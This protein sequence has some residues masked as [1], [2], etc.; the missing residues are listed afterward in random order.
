MGI[1]LKPASDT[2]K[3]GDVVYSP[4]SKD[5]K[6]F[7]I[8]EGYVIA[9]TFDDS[10]KRRIHLIYGP[11]TYFPVLSVFKNSEQRAT[12]ETITSCKI[13]RI[14]RKEFLAKIDQDFEFCKIILEK[15]VDQLAIFA[16]RVIDLQLTK[17]EDRLI[18][19]IAV[20]YKKHG[21]L[22]DGVRQLPY[23]PKHNLLADMLGVER[24][25]VTRALHKLQDSGKIKIQSSGNIILIFGDLSH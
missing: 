6:V 4:F 18:A 7:F 17:L 12:Y 21:I 2:Y 8:K 10:G 25:S 14:S 9:Y 5:K 22:V 20:L 1:D 13:D 16:E 11:G 3:Q 19:R 23:K 15:T 24:E